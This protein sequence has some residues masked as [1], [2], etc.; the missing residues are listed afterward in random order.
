MTSPSAAETIRSNADIITEAA[1]KAVE[2][3]RAMMRH[4][5][6]TGPSLRCGSH[7]IDL[8]D[9]KKAVVIGAGK[10][11]APMAA[12]A[13]RI[14][15]DLI[16]DGI[17]VV[18]DGHVRPTQKITI[19]EASH[20]V[21]DSRSVEA[22][23]KILCL[24]AENAGPETLFI[25]LLSGGASALLAAPAPGITLQDKQEVTRLLLE[26]GAD[27]YEINA[28]RKHLSTIK[29]GNLARAAKGSTMISLV[30]SDVIGDRLDTIG[31]GPAFPDSTT[32]KD[33]YGILQRYHLWEKVPDAVSKRI[34]EGISGQIPDTPSDDD[35]CFRSVVSCIIASNRQ[36]LHAASQ[37]AK[38]LGY[39]TLI[40]SSSIRGETADIAGMHSAI[41]REISESGN[42][43]PPPCCIISGGET[44][45]TMGEDHGIGGRNQEF[46]LAA[47]CEI[48]GLKNLV[49]LSLGTDGT[50]GPT[51]AAGAA[52]TG[53]TADRAK[54]LGLDPIAY[55]RRHDAYTFFKQTG[56]LIMTGPTMTNVMDIHIILVS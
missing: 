39:R 2:P 25:N 14:L 34:K 56:E 37:A 42:P 1:L 47:A 16:Q 53:E 22:A 45:V 18:K 43:L 50:D 24:V 29:G 51:D 30:I 32:W 48:A 49:I 33:V 20:P 23:K 7:I 11:G 55:L 40:L 3:E 46:A 19:L 9:F 15:G 8:S 38:D 13:E 4:I 36:A 17:V 28:V 21:P 6:V 26:C 31:S 44:T 41:A 27:I 52:V 35:P 12:A 10:A 54:K 5:S